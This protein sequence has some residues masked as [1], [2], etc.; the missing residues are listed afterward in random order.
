MDIA[1]VN[2]S[3]ELDGTPFDLNVDGTTLRG[4]HWQC[5]SPIYVVLFF[6]GLCSN[7]E[8][9][10][11]MLRVFPSVNCAC[12]AVD[13]LGN[14]FSDGRRGG[15]TIQDIVREGSELIRYA[16]TLYPTLPLF[17]FGHSMGGLGVVSIAMERI[18]ELNEVSGLVLMAPWITTGPGRLPGWWTLQL[19][20]LI[21]WLW[22]WFVVPTGIDPAKSPYTQ[23]FKDAAARCPRLLHI[24]TIPLVNSVLGAMT[25]AV[26][27]TKIPNMP[28]LFLQ[29]MLDTCVDPP[30]NVEWAN[31]IAEKNEGMVTIKTF[32]GGHHDL[33]KADTRKEA[34]EAIVQFCERVAAVENSV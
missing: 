15:Q 3:L 12:L 18:A 6:H 20:R 4:C 30:A 5:P 1:D 21:S 8:L 33:L 29:G 34:F 14:G 24:A 2:W 31:Q 28:V 25:A 13:A 7:L 17:L 27:V 16:R 10:A 11:N 19:A 23:E 22:P 32:E 26:D 9:N